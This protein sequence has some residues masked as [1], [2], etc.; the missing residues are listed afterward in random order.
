MNETYKDSKGN[1][2]GGSVDNTII[3]KMI[4]NKGVSLGWYDK[5]SNKTYNHKNQFV[6]TGNQL[7]RFFGCLKPSI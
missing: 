2:L 7:T 6:G 4:N 5:K 1:T 3:I